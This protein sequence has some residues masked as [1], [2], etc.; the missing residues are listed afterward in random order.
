MIYAENIL[1]FLAAPFIIGL[2]LLKGDSRRF[3][4]FFLIGSTV[5]LLSS[6]INSFIAG[7]YGMNVIDAIIKITPMIEEVMKALPLLFYMIIFIPKK[8]NILMCS[9]ATGIGFATFENCCYVVAHGADNFYFVL[10]RGFAVGIMHILCSLSLGYSLGL[11]SNQK[12]FSWIGVFTCISICISY[13]AI[14]NLLVTGEGAWQFYGYFMPFVTVVGI[15]II[16]NL[17]TIIKNK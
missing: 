15:I 1:V 11:G 3:V 10:I 7:V 8:E 17:T 2:F 5:C 9:I 4:G 14:Y 13:H 16:K 12:H 6:Y